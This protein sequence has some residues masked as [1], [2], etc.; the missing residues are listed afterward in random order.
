MLLGPVK[1]GLNLIIG[2]NAVVTKDVPIQC[3]FWGAAEII[4]NRWDESTDRRL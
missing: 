4:K 3:N 2:V 1:V